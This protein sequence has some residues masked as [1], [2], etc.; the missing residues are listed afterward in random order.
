M[1]RTATPAARSERNHAGSV[2]IAGR[3]GNV[4]GSVAGRDIINQGVSEQALLAI[5]AAVRAEKGVPTTALA[6]I[7]AHFGDSSAPLDPGEIENRLRAKADEFLELQS[8][9]RRL[10]NDDPAVAKLRTAAADHLNA[11][12][13]SEADATLA[14]AERIDLA[15]VEELES[16]ATQRRLSAAVSRAERAAAARLRLG[17]RE[18]AVHYE[19][20]ATMVPPGDTTARLRY[21][22][23]QV[24]SLYDQG[25]EFGDNP[26]LAEAIH[27]ARSALDLLNR[28]S[29]P[30][31]WAN[32]QIWLGLALQTLGE[33]E[34]GTACLEE[35][36]AAYRAALL[37]HTRDHVP[38]DWAMT[39]N[40]LG[41]ALQTLGERESGTARLEEAVAAYHAALLEHTR[42]RVPLAWAMTQNN[43]GNALQTLGERE[44]GTARLEEA[45]ATYRA[46]LLEHTRDRVPLTGP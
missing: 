23:S 22:W 1:P 4:G 7:L 44:S 14:E 43:L 24:E 34:S 29:A 36:V 39:Q 11:A 10:S 28:Q 17:Y 27:V 32:W 31:D 30:R 25:N 45:V 3:V 16:A 9:L 6:A 26:A 12:R 13:F 21:I 15:A 20:A 37:E 33:R 38:L 41:T 8:R 19:A 2:S 46:A 35:A 40:N 5:V 18:A 42:D